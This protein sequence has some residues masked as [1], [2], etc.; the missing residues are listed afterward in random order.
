MQGKQQLSLLRSGFLFAT[1]LV[2]AS[3][4]ITGDEEVDSTDDAE[5]AAGFEDGQGPLMG[6][7]GRGLDLRMVLVGALCE[8]LR[9][10]CQTKDA[11]LD[12]VV[13][14]VF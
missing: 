8:G 6:F 4:W 3:A 14:V 2:C 11:A 9:W 1:L 12:P 7:L 10:L 13:K 5:C